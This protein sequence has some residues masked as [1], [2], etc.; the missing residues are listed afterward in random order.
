MDKK[1]TAI[2]LTEDICIVL[3]DM[4]VCKTECGVTDIGITFLNGQ[5]FKIV[6]Q[7]E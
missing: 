5:K 1:I 6:I 3:K 7:E 4:F 2:D